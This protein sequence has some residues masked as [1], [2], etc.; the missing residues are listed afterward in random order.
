LKTNKNQEIEFND[1]AFLLDFL[2]NPANRIVV[3]KSTQVGIS[4][5]IILKLLYFT[6]HEDLSVVYTLPTTGDV[7]DFVLSK[8]DPVIESSPTLR[9]K[10]LSDPISKR[11]I[12]SSVLKRIGGSHYFFRSSYVEHKAQS[13][14]ADVLVVD[15]LDFQNPDVRQMFEERLEGASSKDI[16]YWVGTPT[17]PNTGISELWEKSDQRQWY[18]RCPNPKCRKKQTLEFPAN[19]SWKKKTYIC[20]FCRTDLSDEDRK[21]GQWIP[22]YSDREIRGYQFNRLMAPWVSAKKIIKAYKTKKARHF[23]NFILGLPYVE[24][25]LQ[26]SKEE[27]KEA[28]IEDFVFYNFKKEK[29]FMGID[30]GNDFHVLRASV[31]KNCMVVTKALRLRSENEL[32]RALQIFKPDLVGMDM[33]PDQHYARKLQQ[34]FSSTSNFLLFNLRVWNNLKLESNFYDW[35]RSKGIVSLDRTESLDTMMDYL[36]NGRI[37]FLKSMDNREEVFTHLQNLLPS[38]E[39]RFGRK[40]KVYKKLGMDDYAHV[41][42]FLTVLYQI[43]YPEESSVPI[44][45]SFEINEPLKGTAEW[46]KQDLKE[47][48]GRLV[49]DGDVII[50]PPKSF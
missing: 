10:V 7:K 5:S 47:R 37:K 49:S 23:Y 36:R 35:N 50:I 27:F 24:K 42:N 4:F 25:T 26:Y 16:I 41:L 15:E 18:I 11:K 28:T 43:F 40:R 32:E 46:F 14:D 20:R 8:F 17:F 39:S 13:I 33:F 19:I 21:R 6:D 12:F 48:E 9:S 44:V 22:T 45:P 38:Y 3:R 29:T 34:Q 31:N 30:Q 2:R 1:H